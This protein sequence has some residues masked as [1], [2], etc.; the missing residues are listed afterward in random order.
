MSAEIL[1]SM[2]TVKIVMICRQFSS[3]LVEK[4]REKKGG[5]VATPERQ[6]KKLW[7]A[8]SIEEFC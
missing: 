4:A 6:L 1:P 8:V 3:A 2:L 7:N 5:K